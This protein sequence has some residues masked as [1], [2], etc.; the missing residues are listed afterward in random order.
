MEHLNIESVE[1]GLQCDNPKCDWTDKTILISSFD[2]WL[3]KPCPKCG[4]NVL[5][6]E[7]YVNAKKIRAMVD[8]I[9]SLSKEE[10][11]ELNKIS[12]INSIEEFK[13][14]PVLGKI[15]GVQSLVEGEATMTI[16]THKQIKIEKIKNVE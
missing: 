3:N 1:S 13:E 2:A 7:D 16:S 5:T 10:L 4:E 15:D 6:D 14:H 11:D 12:G 8:F 9:N